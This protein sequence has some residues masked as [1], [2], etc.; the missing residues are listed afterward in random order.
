[1]QGPGTASYNETWR[2]PGIRKTKEL[3]KACETEVKGLFNK[4]IKNLTISQGEILIKLI[5]RETGKP[6]LNAKELKRRV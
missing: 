2:L 4:E 6:A 5:N 3:I 1:L